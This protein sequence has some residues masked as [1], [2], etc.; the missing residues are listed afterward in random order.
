MNRGRFIGGA[1]VV[2]I[3][4]VVGGAFMIGQTL[5]SA[6]ESSTSASGGVAE[7][8]AG[9]VT[10]EKESTR[11][12][13]VRV[14]ENV[15]D[16]GNGPV[17][18]KVTTMPA[19]ELPDAPSDVHGVFVSREDNSITVG[20]GAIELNVEIHQA[21]GGAIEPNVSLTANGP[22]IE[23]VVTHDTVIYREETEDPGGSG[24][25][26]KGGEYTVQQ[27]VRQVDSLEELGKNTEV[28]AWGEQRG[29]RIVA[30][31]L[32][33]RIVNPSF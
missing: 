33:Y 20:T 17:S 18:V 14:I 12:R 1:A 5:G 30:D 9:K 32:V 23:V 24:G 16:V 31:I 11:R 19:P 2:L 4:L 26:V 7:A 27:V 28:I 8:S 25:D 13:P 22:E 3:G 21:P 10:T 29:D 15:M 6:D